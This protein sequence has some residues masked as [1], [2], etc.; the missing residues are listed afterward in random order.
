MI[1]KRKTTVEYHSQVFDFIFHMPY[2]IIN[3]YLKFIPGS[4]IYIKINIW[5]CVIY[6]TLTNSWYKYEILLQFHFKFWAKPFHYCRRIIVKRDNEL[7]I[8]WIIYRK[9]YTCPV[10][11]ILVPNYSNWCKY[12]RMFWILYI[13]GTHLR[14]FGSSSI[15]AS[16]CLYGIL[17][18]PQWSGCD[19]W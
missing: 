10:S 16:L 3:C 11:R 5:N 19:G 13:R 8:W 9:S 4:R 18:S 17:F 7:N 14:I 1:L 2:C 6:Y 15:D 12:S